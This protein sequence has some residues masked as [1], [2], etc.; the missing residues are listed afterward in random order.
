MAIKDLYPSINPTLDLNFAGTRTV[1][2]RITFSRASTA[3]YFDEFGVMRTAPANTPRIDF[4]PVKGEC[5]GLFIEEQRTNLLTYSEQF[6][7]SAWVKTRT[8]I[9]VN[10]IV[11][12]DGTLTADKLVEDTQTGAHIAVSGSGLSDNTDYTISVFAKAAE[13]SYI[14][15]AFITKGG[16]IRG[17]IFNLID[18][19]ST[20]PSATGHSTPPSGYTITPVR[21]GWFKCTITHNSNIGANTG[22]FRAHIATDHD[23]FDYTGDGTS[24]IYIW[25]AQLEAGA[26][27]T[28]YIKTEASQV[29][30]AADIATMTGSNFSSWYRQDEGT[31]FADYVLGAGNVSIGVFGT[32][33]T[34]SNNN[35]QMRY[36]DGSQAQFAVTTGG[37]AQVNL[38]PSGYSTTGNYRRAVTYAANSF[39]QAINGVLPSAEDTSGVV[40]VVTR[41]LIGNEGASGNF[42]NGHI[43]RIAYYSKRLSNTNLQG[44]TI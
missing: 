10:T 36:A 26:F 8:T 1:D 11:A 4:D 13:R 33:D 28:S 15:L 40:P 37:V 24:G 41:A 34:T 2:P 27:P 44:I 19:T 5:K 43:R 23:T 30:R 21:N 20:Q 29:T 22:H 17:R 7:N 39:N 42:L 3:T 12:P 9:T 31:L 32:D 16:G 35:N 38:A 18:G 14:Y 6:N 25:G